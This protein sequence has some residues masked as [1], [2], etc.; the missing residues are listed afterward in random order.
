MESIYQT[1]TEGQDTYISAK[2]KFDSNP[3]VILNEIVANCGGFWI[4]P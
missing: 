1:D 3:I 4:C 2:P